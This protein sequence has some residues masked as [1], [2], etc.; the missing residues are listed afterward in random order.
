M[1]C[2]RRLA[3]LRNPLP[4]PRRETNAPSDLPKAGRDTGAAAFRNAGQKRCAC[5]LR[6][7]WI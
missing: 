1:T 6:W 7:Y 4:L 5:C 3:S 2:A